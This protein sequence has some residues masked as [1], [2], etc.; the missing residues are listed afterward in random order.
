M[1]SLLFDT[2]DAPLDPHRGWALD[3]RFELGLPAFAGPLPGAAP[4]WR[5]LVGAQGYIRLATAHLWRLE[6]GDYVG[7]DLVL[8]LSLS[9]DAAGPIG[10]GGFV[11]SSET[12]AYGGDFS[13]RGLPKD[14]SRAAIEALAAA[15]ASAE[16]RLYLLRLGFGTLQLA[17]FVDLGTVAGSSD[18]LFVQTTCTAGPALRYVTPVGPLSL[19]WGLPMHMAPA[20]RDVAPPHGRLH[21][22]FGYAF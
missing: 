20:L 3:G 11:P 18:G 13:V 6:A 9:Y 1:P 21:F 14:A 7:G 4:F 8:A 5:T 16:L 2:R 19:A 15:T 12:F 10:A 17:G 22:S